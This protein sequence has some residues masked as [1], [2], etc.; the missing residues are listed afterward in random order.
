MQSNLNILPLKSLGLQKRRPKQKK[1]VASEINDLNGKH[2]IKLRAKKISNGVH[3][4]Y[5]QYRHDCKQ[6]Y[7]YLKIYI[8]GTPDRKVKD[9][10]ALRLAISI[11][12]KKE[13]ELFENKYDFNLYNQKS[14]ANFI[15]YF[16]SIV[17][18]KVKK[19]HTID[20]SWKHVSMHLKIYTKNKPVSF[21]QIDE[22]FCE[23]FKDYLSKVIA[24][25]T[26]HTYFSK[27]KACLN[28]AI[29]N[30]IITVNP[31]KHL[32][33]RKAE[34][35]REFLTYD[36]LVLLKNTP[37]MSEETKNAFLFSCFTGLRISDLRRLTWGNI[38]NGFLV[39]EQ[40]KT[41]SFQ[42]MLLCESALDCLRNQPKGNADDL[43]FNLVTNDNGRRHIKKWVKAA[44][45]KKHIFWH[46]A[47][48]SFATLNLTFGNDI[49]T[50]SKLL[51]HKSVKI[52]EQYTKLVD[53]KKE[54]AILRLPK[55]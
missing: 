9:K 22:K 28:T 5:L 26:A 45:I 53:K 51:G 16:D 23:G 35:Y 32:H 44:D 7:L 15:E 2:L 47:R 34:T 14:K 40:M 24:P 20:K 52:T 55:I 17:Q 1:T 6:E 21:R 25:N 30:K 29:K 33:I 11:R 38:K 49:Y 43:V 12:D 13:L 31:A 46:S 39:F 36:E 19:D 41:E 8:Y 54:E 48:H 4:L 27:L 10:E 50:V 37:C 3:S 18:T 42:R